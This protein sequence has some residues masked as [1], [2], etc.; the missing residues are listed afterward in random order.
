MGSRPRHPDKEIEAAVT[1]AEQHGWV[2]FKVK[3]HAWGKLYCTRHDRDGCR[4]FVWS[5]PKSPGN[6]ARQLKRMVDHCP[7]KDEP[8]ER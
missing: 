3:G 6:H 8:R 4:L 5:T 2:W 7:H 1:Y